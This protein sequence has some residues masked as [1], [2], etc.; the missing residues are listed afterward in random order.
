MVKNTRTALVA[1]R[2]STIH[3]AGVFALRDIA[4]GERIIEYVGERITKAESDRRATAQLE[5]SKMKKSAGAVYIFEIN[6]RYDLDGDVPYNLAKYI[7]HSC[8]PNAKSE[9]DRGHIW[10]LAKRAIAKGEEITYDYGYDIDN[11]RDHPC[12]CGSAHCVGYIVRR[13]Q[14][15]KLKTLLALLRK[16]GAKKRN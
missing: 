12:R 3:N 1:R 7:N 9:N 11:Y 8:E 4:K 14:W 5:K 13:S 6:K 10:I 16:K 15:K 2:R